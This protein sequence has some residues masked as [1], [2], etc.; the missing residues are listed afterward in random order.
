M[1]PGRFAV[2]LAAATVVMGA[3]AGGSR[4]EVTAIR[5]GTLVDG[6]GGVLRNA[7]VVI[8]SERVKS[9]GTTVPPGAR[10]VDLSRFT[11]VPGLIDVHTH[12][13]YNWDPKSG[14]R[15]F[16][17]SMFDEHPAVTVFKARINATRT[18][19]SGVTTVRDLG[20]MQDNDVAM[21][22]L[23]N[24]GLITGP[25][26][27]VSGIPLQVTYA[28][29]R[30]H[31]DFPYPGIANGVPEVLAAVRREV[32]GAG[33]DWVKM[34]GS[35]GSG[36][37]VSTRQTF[38]FEEMK[39]AA[40][41]A[42][43]LGVR[44]AVHSYGPEGARDAVR[45][46]ANSIEHAVDIDDATLAEMRKRGTF[47]VPTVDHN[48]Y[49]AE[50]ATEFGYEPEVV[51]GL[52]AYRERNL[53]TV[54]RAHKAGVRIAMGSDALFTMCGE[55]TRELR[56]FVQAGMTPSEALA[57]ATTT[58]AA[59]LGKEAE[60][61]AVAPGFLADL[62]AVDGD[63]LKDIGAVVDHV[64]WVMKAGVVVVDRTVGPPAK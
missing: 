20:A 42:H 33:A 41:A 62:V 14:A 30:P 6:K 3:F 16:D 53:A 40:D 55:N 39:A 51:K 21:R 31:L 29:S 37:D 59:L 18:L 48:R 47:Y 32:M 26:M 36:G 61:G 64:V 10:V 13:T 45:A 27:F 58:A 7:V 34:F 4:A 44:L 1:T 49:Y 28:S 35:T 38:T 46:G 17:P 54:R 15:P 43:A 5:F 11:G 52:D 57:S 60:L 2:A 19:E 63:P 56:W 9:V 12:L 8:D 24:A 23:V 50:H 25:R 22:D